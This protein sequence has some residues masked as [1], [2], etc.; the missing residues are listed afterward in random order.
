MICICIMNAYRSIKRR[1]SLL[2]LYHLCWSHC[3]SWSPRW[4][5]RNDSQLC[6]LSWSISEIS[7]S[8][9]WKRVAHWACHDSQSRLLRHFAPRP[10]VEL[11]LHFEK[12]VLVLY[13][14][15]VKGYTYFSKRRELPSN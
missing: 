3:L 9:W 4:V 10:G 7:H 2:S 8:L 14:C 13:G 6:V 11:G 15:F 1:L 12:Y 5:S